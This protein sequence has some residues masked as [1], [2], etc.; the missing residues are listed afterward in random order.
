MRF[1]MDYQNVPRF[2]L[3]TISITRVQTR[4]IKKEIYF[5]NRCV[6]ILKLNY[7]FGTGLAKKK[8]LNKITNY[9]IILK[10]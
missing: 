2:E 1:V 3:N 4:G 10:I 9:H 8:K 5:I 6:T 7:F